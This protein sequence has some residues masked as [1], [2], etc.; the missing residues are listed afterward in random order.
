MFYSHVHPLITNAPQHTENSKLI[1]YSNQ[2]TGFCMMRNTGREASNRLILAVLN[3]H[4]GFN[5]PAALS[6]QTFRYHQA[7]KGL[8]KLVS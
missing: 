3:G 7:F 2:F 8:K 4:T 6:K 5:K 1:C